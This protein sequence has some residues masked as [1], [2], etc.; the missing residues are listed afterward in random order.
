MRDAKRIPETL[1]EL[2]KVW[3]SNPDLRLGQIFNILQ[4][5]AN[6]DLFYIEDDKLIELLKVTFEEIQGE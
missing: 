3:E 6:N 1:E 5:K 2:E 4:T